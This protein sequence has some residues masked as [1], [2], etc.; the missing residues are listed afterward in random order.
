MTW[1]IELIRALFLVLCGVLGTAQTSTNT[2]IDIT[3][4]PTCT[5]SPDG[6]I[7]T[8]PANGSSLCTIAGTWTFDPIPDGN[9]DY[10]IRLNGIIQSTALLP[11]CGAVQLYVLNNGTL[12]Q[13]TSG[14]SWYSWT[15]FGFWTGP[16]S[17]P[18]VT[19][20]AVAAVAGF[21]QLII[22]DDF[23][24][25]TFA[26]PATWYDC[27]M[28]GG[29]PL[30]W[31]SWLGFNPSGY[32]PCNSVSQAIDPL[33]NQLA[34]RIHW[35]DSYIQTPGPGV[36]NIAVIQTV[37]DFGN[38][39]KTPRGFYLEVRARTDLKTGG[40]PL[41]W[42]ALWSYADNNGVN[43]S[44]E[45]DGAEE[46][47]FSGVSFAIH[48][49]VTNY[50]NCANPGQ[51]CAPGAVDI[52]Q[53][54]TYAWRQTSAGTDIV[55]CAY[56]DG[57]LYGCNS[58]QPAASQLSPGTPMVH[59]FDVGTST[60]LGNGSTGKNVWLESVKVWSCAGLNS[61]VNCNSSSNN[62]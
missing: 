4:T 36:A 26:N 41:P 17:D 44:Y 11:C 20:P 34:V 42:M 49:N 27:A 1:I 3:V 58:I 28:S 15:G 21:N 33:T 46:A 14:G 51:G 56:I 59:Q 19:V 32:A 30:Y 10:P 38:G 24:S 31:R 54:H 18:R 23:Q 60:P 22:N 50:N 37:D 52:T 5:P 39:R 48:N 7:L 61:G 25:A 13:L 16:V 8:A 40:Y 62:P 53:Y 43:G 55:F 9:G 57:I 35:Q 12:Y 47:G 6:S 29:S 2:G 45:I